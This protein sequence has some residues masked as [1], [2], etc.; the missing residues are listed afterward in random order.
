MK[1]NINFIYFIIITFIVSDILPQAYGT[2]AVLD[3]YKFNSS[4]KSP[5]L[6]RGDLKKL[7]DRFSLKQFAPIPGDQGNS[8]TCTGWAT[9]YAART[10]MEA[11]ENDWSRDEINKRAFSPSYV[12]NQIRL[13]DGCEYGTSIIDGLEILTNDG[14]LPFEDFGYDCDRNVNEKDKLKASNF[15]IKEY[16]EIINRQTKNKTLNIKKSLTQLKPIVAGI[17]C[18]KS[19][20]RAADVWHPEKED[21][22]SN[23]SGHAVTVVGYNDDIEGGSFE[24]MN[25]WGSKWGN[26]GFIWIRYSDFEHFC[27][28]AGELIADSKNSNA[29]HIDYEVYLTKYQGGQIHFQKSITTY[30]TVDTFYTGDKFQL[31]L[32]NKSPAYVY[33]LS[34]DTVKGIESMYPVNDNTSDFLAY[35]EHEVI[36][37]S[38]DYAFEL[39]DEFGI[40]SL[41]VLVATV[42]IKNELKDIFSNK[43]ID[44]NYLINSLSNEALK[45]Y[46]DSELVD[47]SLITLNTVRKQNF[48]SILKI[49]IN[50]AFRE[51]E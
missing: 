48:I 45:I 9:S 30:K 4:P 37:P 29:L 7:P 44:F 49:D 42:S 3:E 17:T 51:V 26:N 21:Y 36:I 25:S 46:F 15:K 12:Y 41:I 22:Q 24:I 6:T 27:V 5:P 28:W 18:P 32:T 33:V 38:E 23:I 34:Y 1:N 16:R 20:Y 50:H 31:Y 47:N 35:S 13:G 40:S 10:I 19:L 11:I 43:K 2:G 39:D 14:V 8:S